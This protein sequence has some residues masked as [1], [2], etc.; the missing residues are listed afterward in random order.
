MLASDPRSLSSA[1]FY[2]PASTWLLLRTDDRCGQGYLFLSVS[3]MDEAA[4]RFNTRR[5]FDDRKRGWLLKIYGS[6]A[7]ELGWMLDLC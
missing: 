1:V 6:A 2:S 4:D 7:R 5:D 3:E